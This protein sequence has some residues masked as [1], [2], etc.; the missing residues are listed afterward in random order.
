MVSK[1]IQEMPF[2]SIRKLTPFANQAKKEGKSVYHLNIGAPDV[3]TPKAFFQAIKEADVD[4][5]S[6]SPSQGIPEL[7]EANAQYFQKIGL[8][9]TR[10][11]LV[12]T[13]GGSEAL[14][15]SLLA[16][17]DVGDQVLTCEPFYTNY[18]TFFHEVG[19]SPTT[20]PTDVKEGFALPA[21]EVIEKAITDKTKVILISNPGNPTGAVYSKE[22]VR[23][24]GDIAKDHDLFILADEVY[25]E[26]IYDGKEFTSFASF[27]D[28]ADRVIVL[29][30]ISKRFSA[31]G[32]RIGC[33]A[34]KNKAMQ[35]ALVKL[36]TGR[37][38]CPYL[39]QVGAVALYQLPDDYFD[40]VREEY[41]LR[42]N[43]IEAELAKIPG[44]VTSHSTGAFYIIADLPVEDAEDFARFMLTD[45][46]DQGET[47]M[48]AP[49]AGFYQ[50]TQVGKSQVRLAYVLES[51]KI[52][53]ACQLIG[54]ALE[55]YKKR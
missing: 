49:A 20:F 37:L 2:S 1:R 51:E 7:L 5:L 40:Q 42:R 22:E 30:S 32:A 55:E 45:F 54:L 17:T 35:E 8:N 14:L 29:D 39:E 11:D 23:L 28:L 27:E 21:R 4:V 15:F 48:M 16:T 38:A 53:R 24:L 26:F 18:K 50:N 6:Y 31:C 13:N 3:L 34:T 41:T 44:V 10:D 9:F 47:V 46:Q 52:A 36:A 12:I 19:V 33:T 25:R 43:R